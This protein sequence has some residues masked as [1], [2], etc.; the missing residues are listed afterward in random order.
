MKGDS[1]EDKQW[2]TTAIL[3]GLFTSVFMY[4]PVIG[5]LW[6]FILVCVGQGAYLGWQNVSSAQARLGALT[7][8][9]ATFLLIPVMGLIFKNNGPDNLWAIGAVMGLVPGLVVMWGA[10]FARS[11]R[12]NGG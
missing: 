8:G 10:R 3:A 7:F 11:R 5:G 9:A 4:L 12:A 2:M 1:L 6:A